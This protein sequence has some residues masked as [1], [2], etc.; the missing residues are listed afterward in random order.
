MACLCLLCVTPGGFSTHVKSRRI[1]ISAI[2][3]VGR[4]HNSFVLIYSARVH[5]SD[6]WKNVLML[7]CS[8]HDVSYT[9]EVPSDKGACG[10]SVV[11]DFNWP[12]SVISFGDWWLCAQS[13]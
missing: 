5:I 3:L 1:I 2:E 8:S 12:G 6:D 4:A 10:T 11:P 13:A 7:L 9:V